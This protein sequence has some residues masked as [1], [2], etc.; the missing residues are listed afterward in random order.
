MNFISSHLEMEGRRRAPY[1]KDKW[2]LERVD[3]RHDRLGVFCDNVS[4]GIM[5][6]LSEY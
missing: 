3:R 6:T 5:L 2:A 4:L 1:G